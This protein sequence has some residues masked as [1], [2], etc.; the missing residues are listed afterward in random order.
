MA[1]K[2]PVR[3]NTFQKI[4]GVGQIKFSPDG[5]FVG[6]KLQKDGQEFVYKVERSNAPDNVKEGRWFVNLSS[7]GKTL[8]SIRPVN[9]LF[10]VGNVKIVTREGVPPAPKVNQQYGYQFFIVLLEITEGENAGMKIPM[11]LHY[12]FGE[13]VDEDGDSVVAI[14]KPMSKHT[15]ALR[16][17]L[18]AVGA[19]EEGKIRYRDNILPELARRITKQNKKFQVVLEGGFVSNIL[20]DESG[21]DDNESEE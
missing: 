11:I 2:P 9:G 13:A 10:T 21:E 14:V 3:G 1:Y 6:V 4:E 5:K 20:I 7:D 16:K 12:N 8:F 19:W 15:I 17:F 18:N